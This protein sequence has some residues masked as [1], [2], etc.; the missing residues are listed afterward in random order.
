MNKRSSEESSLRKRRSPFAP[1]DD[2]PLPADCWYMIYD[3][4][5][6]RDDRIKLKLL[7]KS[8]CAL[9]TRR[10]QS[11]LVVGILQRDLSAALE[12][13]QRRQNPAPWLATPNLR[14]LLLDGYQPVRSI[15]PWMVRHIILS[16]RHRTTTPITLKIYSALLLGDYLLRIPG[17]RLSQTFHT[18]RFE[19]CYDMCYMSHNLHVD[20][21]GVTIYTPTAWDCTKSYSPKP[22]EYAPLK[23]IFYGPSDNATETTQWLSNLFGT[24][25]VF[26]T[27]WC[28]D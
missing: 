1:I 27:S 10:C 17:K 7:N 6:K 24:N 14:T 9:F 18:L 25:T 8:A 16:I 11:I 2:N 22:P 23:V 21:S 28:R 26:E 3:M 5:Y 4:L 20:L 19:T 15:S 13:S 12:Y